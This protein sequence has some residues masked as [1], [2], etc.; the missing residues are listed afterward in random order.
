MDKEQLSSFF[1]ISL[2][3]ITP[4][5]ASPLI[6]SWYFDIGDLTQVI[7]FPLLAILLPTL[8]GITVI[9]LLCGWE[10]AF[11]GI[12]IFVVLTGIFCVLSIGNKALIDSP[13]VKLH[14]V[15]YQESGFD[16]WFRENGTVKCKEVDMLSS[17]D[18]YGRYEIREDTIF[19]RNIDITYGLSE[20]NDT[21]YFKED[22]LV[23]RLDKEWRRILEGSMY[24]KKDIR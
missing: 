16:L 21:M 19:L 7:L 15:F 18:K 20:V 23:F 3:I 11:L 13:T 4:F 22:E 1:S 12:Y 17:T 24:I 8:V 10:R 14:A 9:A 2:G 5:I 6:Y